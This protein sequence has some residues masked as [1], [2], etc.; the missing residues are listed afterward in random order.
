MLMPEYT[1]H[2]HFLSSSL[3]FS[4]IRTET[5]EIVASIELTPKPT[6]EQRWL[7]SSL[8]VETVPMQIIEVQSTAENKALPPVRFF[9]SQDGQ[10]IPESEAWFFESRAL[11]P[12][13]LEED[14]NYLAN[15]GL[16]EK[17]T[18]LSFLL[19]ATKEN[20]KSLLAI[21]IHTLTI[22]TPAKQMLDKW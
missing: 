5:G 2:P 17:P 3:K 22:R 7:A 14:A 20:P 13:L 9:I 19:A 16:S 18:I 1:D 15:C 4:K 21:A 12:R 8:E 6:E 11:Q 10:V